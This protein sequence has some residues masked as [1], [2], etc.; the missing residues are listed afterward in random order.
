MYA[1]REI[2][3]IT[4]HTS[5]SISIHKTYIF[6]NQYQHLVNLLLS[7]T[8]IQELYFMSRI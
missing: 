8:E 4:I 5:Y 1:G 6:Y 3:N 2:F 7:I